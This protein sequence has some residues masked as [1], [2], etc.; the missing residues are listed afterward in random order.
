MALQTARSYHY[1]LM[2][3]A[4][5]LGLSYLLILN[6]STADMIQ[7]ALQIGV[8]VLITGAALLWVLRGQRSATPAGKALLVWTAIYLIVLIFSID[9]RRS[10]SQMELMAL[11]IFL[12]AF[13]ADLVARGWPR[14]LLVKTLLMTGGV[15][16]LLGFLEVALW[17][18]SWLQ[19]APG[20]WIPD[21]LYRPNNANV[22][23]MFVNLVILLAGA[24]L[25]LTRSRA[26]RA[27]LCLLLIASFWLL[28]LTSSRGGWLGAAAGLAV[29]FGS[30]VITGQVNW[31]AGWAFLQA[32]TV[33][34]VVLGVLFLGAV[35]L[36]GSLLYQRTIHPSHAPVST[37]RSE[38]WPPAWQ[39]FLESPLVGKGQFTYS[40]SFLRNNSV[41]NKYLYIHSHGTYFNLL[42]EM[43]LFGLAG[44]T[45]LVITLCRG[46][47]RSLRQFKGH[48]LS[49]ALGACGAVTA[50][51]VH[52]IFDCFHTEPI[53]LWSLAIVLGAALGKTKPAPRLGRMQNAWVLLLV[54]ALWF[55]VWATAPLHQGADLANALRWQEAVSAFDA[56]V[57]RDPASVIAYQ[58]RGLAN[59]ILAEQGVPGALDQAVRDFEEVI[60]REPAWAFNHANLGALYLAQGRAE[61]ARL[62]F[63]ES[64]RRAP[65]CASCAFNLGASLEVLG[66]EAAAT[67]SYQQALELGQPSE[68]YFWRS[69]DLRQKAHHQWVSAHPSALS[70]SL[71]DLKRDLQANPSDLRVYLQVIDREVRQNH[72]EEA[73]T[74]LSKAGMAFSNSAAERLARDW[75]SVELLARQGQTEMALQRG[76]AVYTSY[77]MQGIYGPGSLGILYYAPLMFRRPAMALEVVPQLITIALPDEWGQHVAQLASWHEQV[78]NVER[79]SHLRRDLQEAIPDYLFNA[80]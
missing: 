19:A 40:A 45:F 58:Q 9:P 10:F 30:A 15:V 76:D 53:G 8:A 21:V 26:A 66:D 68:A 6:G 48:D 61:D 37:A 55:E 59:S 25:L 35:L 12:F 3:A 31:R 49:V 44:L 16:V 75:L 57:K 79:A 29:L 17:Y 62:A 18:A 72:L 39:A 7:P 80:K 73:E 60:R 71:E 52:S 69:T 1:L 64:L 38:Y 11:S 42:A 43:G 56:A 14:E 33:L 54:G 36:G 77:Q 63:E 23:A 50:V 32:H 20:Q 51:A 65:Q 22:V 67:Q 4:L 70:G 74:L 47:W 2:E 5:F 27:A 41:P 13:S 24:R 78:G 46:L 34:R 28:Y